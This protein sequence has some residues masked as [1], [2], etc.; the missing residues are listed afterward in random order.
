MALSTYS[1][2]QTSITNWLHRADLSSQIPDFIAL[3]EADIYRRLRVT[4]MENT[5]T[6]TLS[7]ETLALPTGFRELR[8]IQLNTDPVIL[9]KYMA[10]ADMDM[11]Y[12]GTSGKPM[13]YCIIGNEFQFAPVP[14][15]SYTVQYTYWAAFDPL[16]TTSTN[17]LLTNHPDVFLY[18]SLIQSAPYIQNDQRLIVWEKMYEQALSRVI[19]EDERKKYG[20]HLEMRPAVAGV[21]RR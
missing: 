9:L 11:R 4:N 7:A 21:D 3:A 8:N 15:G 2:L 19:L 10:P 12:G 17:W 6:D 18:G 5:G 1:D 14:D 13:F 20:G 16:S